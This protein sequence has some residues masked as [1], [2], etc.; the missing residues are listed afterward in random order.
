M[1]HGYYELEYDNEKERG[2]TEVPAQHREQPRNEF[3]NISMRLHPSISAPPLPLPSLIP[4]LSSE[5]KIPT[6]P[7]RTLGGLG[8]CDDLARVSLGREQYRSVSGEKS[9]PSRT[10]RPHLE[11]GDVRGTRVASAKPAFKPRHLC[12]V[13][14]VR[15]CPVLYAVAVAAA[16]DEELV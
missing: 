4:N 10:L 2:E 9:R 1:E 7:G 16:I 13:A 8:C 15:A 3:H 11:Q 14:S 5:K 6:T 12:S